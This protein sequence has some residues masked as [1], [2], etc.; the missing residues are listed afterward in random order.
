[1]IVLILNIFPQLKSQ[2]ELKETTTEKLEALVGHFIL[3]WNSSE[4]RIHSARH[5]NKT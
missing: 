2:I 3:A 1:M 4:V 5:V